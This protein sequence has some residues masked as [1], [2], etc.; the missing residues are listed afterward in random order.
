MNA[1]KALK[2]SILAA[3]CGGCTS[4]ASMRERHAQED[5]ARYET[6]LRDGKAFALKRSVAARGSRTCTIVQW[7]SAFKTQREAERRAT[8]HFEGERST[9][10][11]M[12]LRSRVGFLMD[13][14]G[15][16][17]MVAS[18]ST[19]PHSNMFL[20]IDGQR[21]R[22]S[23]A[24][25]IPITGRTLQALIDEK[26]FDYSYSTWPT[27]ENAGRDVF[28]GFRAVMEECRAYVSTRSG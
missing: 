25:G 1:A 7:E 4:L 13:R 16:L 28:R 3:A 23:E 27:G 5:R 26:P 21:L 6:I 19:F 14:T 15:S 8:S 20:V 22:A 2:L 17:R 24:T 18:F 10:P 9:V 12:A 11:S